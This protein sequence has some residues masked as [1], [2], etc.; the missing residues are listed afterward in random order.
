MLIKMVKIYIINHTFT[1]IWLWMS[2]LGTLFNFK[3]KYAC[4]IAE[5]S[6]QNNS[7]CWY[8]DSIWA[9][10]F[11]IEL[12]SLSSKGQLSYTHHDL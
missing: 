1:N 5:K 2:D 8:N 11:R 4:Q 12:A 9:N 6:S 7:Q 10:V 3:R